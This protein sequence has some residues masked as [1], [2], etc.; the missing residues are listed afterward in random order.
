MDG[1]VIRTE[2]LTKLYGKSRGIIGV[3]FEVRAGEIFGFLGP[4]GAGKTTTIRLLLDFIRPTSGS[5]ELFG[6]DSRKGSVAIHRRTGYLPG[7]LALYEKMTGAD[8]ARFF[9]NLRGGVDWSYVD[10]LAQRLDS[11]LSVPIRSLSR[12]NK[13]KVGLIQALM[14]GPELLILDEPTAGLDPLIQQE[15]YRIIEAC[16]EEGRTAFVSSH[17][18][19]E[20]ERLCDRVGIIREGRLVD[21]EEISAIKQRAL[22]HL[23]I[24]FAA[25]P[26]PE[27]LSGIP[28]LRDLRMEGETLYCTIQGS[29]DALV[30][31]IARYEVSNIL[32]YETPLEDIFLAYYGEGE[33]DAQ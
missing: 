7:E 31:A 30:K 18:L 14:H 28:G 20:V 9:A 22:H 12:G 23:E 10:E 13:Q 16:R 17:N 32:S 1:T 26:P 5:A 27:T 24:H 29:M 2:G 25:A 19:H 8:L 6:L 21:V 3:D 33:N 15:F 4:N 11:D